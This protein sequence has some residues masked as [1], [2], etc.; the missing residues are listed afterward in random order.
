MRKDFNYP[1]LDKEFRQG[2]FAGVSITIGLIAI[3]IMCYAF[4]HPE[5]LGR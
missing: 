4:F 5:I 3:G 2:V 1:D